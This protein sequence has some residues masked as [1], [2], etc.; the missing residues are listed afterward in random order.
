MK[1][2]VWLQSFHTAPKI[3]FVLQIPFVALCESQLGVSH[4]YK[5]YAKLGLEEILKTMVPCKL[6]ICTRHCVVE[7]SISLF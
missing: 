4:G 5:A 1:Y 3:S 6:G 2:L 7:A